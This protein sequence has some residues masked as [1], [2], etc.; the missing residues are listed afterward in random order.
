MALIPGPAR[1]AGGEGMPTHGVLL[2]I[3]AAAFSALALL[4]WAVRAA[5]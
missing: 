1:G 5:G 3:I 4:P 2:R